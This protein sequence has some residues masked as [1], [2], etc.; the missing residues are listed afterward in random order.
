MIFNAEQATKTSNK[1]KALITLTSILFA[2]TLSSIASAEELKRHHALSLIGTPKYAPDFKHFDY[3]NPSAPKGGTV[4]MADIGGFDSL[5]PISFKGVAASGLGFIYETLMHDSIEEPST[6]YGLIAE[7]ATYPAD[8]SSV[9]FKLRENAKWHDGKPIT[10]EDV[11]FSLEMM[12]KVNPRMAFYYKNITKAEKTGEGLVTFSFDVKNN[13]ELPMITGQLT[14]LPKHY[15]TAKDKDGETRDLSKTTL[16]PPLGSGPY[17]IAEAQAGRS[18]T[19]ERVKDYWGKD[20]PVNV[21]HYNFDKIRFDTFKDSTVSFEA[22]KAGQLDF[23]Q[24]TSSKNWATG[25]KFKAV[26]K[27]QVAQQLVTLKNGQPMQAFMF[28]TRRSKFSDPRVRQAFNLAFDFEWANQNLFYGQ[29]KRV[30][31]Y[32]EN[33]E[34]AARGLPEG[35]E[36]EILQTVKDEVPPEVFTTE[37]KNPVGGPK[38]LRKNL[39]KAKKLLTDAGWTISSGGKPVLKNEKGETFEVEFLLISPAFERIVQPFLRN[40]ERLGINGTIRLVDAAQYK[41]RLDSFDFDMIVFTIGQSNS[42]GN[43]Q[44]YYWGSKAADENGSRNMIGIKNPAIDKLIDKV[45]FAKDRAE[46]VAATKALD[47]VLLWNHYVV[48]QWFSPNERIAYWKRFG[49]PK[50]LPSL[51]VGFPAVWWWDKNADDALSSSR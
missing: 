50:T 2:A 14:V 27:G 15:W 9:T 44:R 32:F 36:L 17:K 7:W 5:N 18:V 20:L 10:V 47:R 29:Y 16:E 23:Y 49:Q 8:Y 28:N 35:Q 3:V 13:R 37:Y 25:Y 46:L 4:R 26:N 38:N 40:L 39:R 30:S 11:I 6:S 45:I 43:E 51:S 1:I 24:E 21:G 19:Y 41:R 42:P 33:S 48:P 34:L 12:K 22:F 31:S